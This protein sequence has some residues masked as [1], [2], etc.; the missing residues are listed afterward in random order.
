MAVTSI[1]YHNGSFYDRE[2]RP[3]GFTP[4]CLRA[5]V[6]LTNSGQVLVGS[7]G[8]R[9]RVYAVLANAAADT[10]IKFQS[11]STDISGT[12]SIAGKGGFVIPHNPNGWFETVLAEALNLNM[13]TPTTVG[14]Q[15]LYGLVS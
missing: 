5:G 7:A 1:L 3:L 13:S 4:D 12:F 14:L 2:G 11:N 15:V 9:I 6:T 8:L 10:S